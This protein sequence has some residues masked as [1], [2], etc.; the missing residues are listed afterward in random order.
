MKKTEILE[1]IG[2]RAFE[3]FGAAKGRGRGYHCRARGYIT[4]R[5]RSQ[6]QEPRPR[7]S[8]PRP[9]WSV[10]KDLCEG[11]G[12]WFSPPHPRYYAALGESSWSNRD[13]GCDGS[14]THKSFP[15]FIYFLYYFYLL[16]FSD[17]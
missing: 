3:V 5:T 17:D 12:R 8:P 13:R 7:F 10:R 16:V 1:A 4:E 2:S 9:R 11:R 6:E 15:R 14:V